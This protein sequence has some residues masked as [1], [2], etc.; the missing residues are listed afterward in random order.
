VENLTRRLARH[1]RVTLLTYGEAGDGHD[2]DELQAGLHAVCRVPLRRP[3]RPRR[4]RQLASL[5]RRS[6]FH[7]GDLRTRAMQRAIDTLIRSGDFD[8]VQVESSQLMCFDFPGGRPL[9]LDEYNIEHALLRRVARLEASPARKLF[10]HLEA[11]KVEREERRAWARVDGCVALSPLDEALVRAGY[12]GVRTAVVPN[13]VDTD[14]FGPA[15]GPVDPESMVFVGMMNYRPNAD[16]VLWFA[17]EVLPRIRSRRPSATL[18]VVGGGAPSSVRKLGGPRVT[19]TGRVDDVRPFMARAGVVI[20]PLRA[21][22]G[23]RHKVL[24]ALSMGKAVVST[25]L[26]AEG[27]EV[28]NREH[29]IMVDDPDEMADRI[30]DVMSDA[31]LRDRLALAGRALMLERYGWDAAA[32]RLEAFHDE[33]A[34][35]HRAG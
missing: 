32:L 17:A 6:S 15:D 12:P 29:L 14:Y 11:A 35:A 19:L 16:G 34:G 13:A 8:I 2:W 21:G 33:V 1:H 25:T 10:G 3:L 9:V 18:T 23:T 20:T 30:L 24:D 28:V 27:I 26:G 4:V 5:A 7:V 22:G 31:S